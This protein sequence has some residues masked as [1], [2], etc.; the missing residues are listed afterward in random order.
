MCVVL[1]FFFFLF[2]PSADPTSGLR[3]LH[4]PYR[5]TETEI[6]KQS[7]RKKPSMAFHPLLLLFTSNE[8]SSGTCVSSAPMEREREKQLLLQNYIHPIYFALPSRATLPFYS[9]T[10]SYCNCNSELHLHP[11]RPL[12]SV[13]LPSFLSFEATRYERSRALGGG[14]CE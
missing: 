2:P 5:E 9:I 11:R 1:C 12:L 10:V 4:R 7:T 13:F 8:Q 14:I 6:D 3:A